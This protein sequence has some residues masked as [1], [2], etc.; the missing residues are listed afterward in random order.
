MYYSLYFQDKHQ[1]AIVYNG[2]SKAFNVVCH[3][4]LFAR[5]FSY[6]IHGVLLSWLQQLFTDRSHCTKVSRSLSEDADLL[7]GVIQGSVIGPLMFLIYI[8]ELVDILDSFGI[9]AKVFADDFKLYI[10]IINEVGVTTLQE[11]LNVLAN[12]LYAIARSS[13]CLSVCLSVVCRL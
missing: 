13:V 4:K 10:R 9:K 8:D 2:F 7:S 12:V 3:K 11:A 1:V 5:L 6:G